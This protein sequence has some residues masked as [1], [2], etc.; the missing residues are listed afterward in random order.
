MENQN[1]VETHWTDTPLLLKV[2]KQHNCKSCRY[3]ILP[4][5]YAIR[6]SGLAYIDATNTVRS[7]YYEHYPDCPRSS[8]ANKQLT[9]T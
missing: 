4:G 9:K 5:S 6:S 3:K 1:Q 2:Q 7:D 8:E